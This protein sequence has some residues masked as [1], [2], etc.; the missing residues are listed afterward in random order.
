M[1]RA[2]AK[3]AEAERLRRA[4]VIS[5]KGEAQAAANILEAAEVLHK[6]SEA[7]HIRYLT[8]MLDMAG[9]RTSTVLFPLPIDLL[10]GLRDGRLGE[11]LSGGPD[12]PEA[13]PSPDT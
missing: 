2:I 8:A 6:R 9:D 10:A 4:K 1:I 7:M 13:D 5:A 11:L 12:R 3:E